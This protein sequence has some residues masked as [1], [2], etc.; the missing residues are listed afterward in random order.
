LAAFF[1]LPGP[2]PPG[3][4]SRRNVLSLAER[5]KG[6][7]I[8]TRVANMAPRVRGRLRNKVSTARN[9]SITFFF[10]IALRMRV[11]VR[12]DASNRPIFR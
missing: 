2:V 7:L 8:A 10:V 9:I 5:R 4:D 12:A 3:F 1:G 11:I 6:Y